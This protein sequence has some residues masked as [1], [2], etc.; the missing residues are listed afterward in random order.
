M[1]KVEIRLRSIVDSLFSTEEMAEY[2]NHTFRVVE[3][4]KYISQKEDA[5]NR[6]LVPAGYLHDIGRIVLTDIK[7]HVEKSVFLSNIILRHLG[8]DEESIRLICIAIEDHHKNDVLPR[9]L[10]GKILYDADK[11]EI[12]GEYG[13]A[14]WFVGNLTIKEAAEKYLALA[15]VATI[16][17]ETFFITK[18]GKQLGNKAFHFSVEFC[19]KVLEELGQAP[20]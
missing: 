17:R 7:G 14:R 11:L 3:K 16:N 1:E 18:T 20:H 4:C 19:K 15:K 5:D 12:V 9:T 2:K 6:I 8:Y 13:I 10:E